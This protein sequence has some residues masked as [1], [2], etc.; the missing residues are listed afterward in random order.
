VPEKE[1]RRDGADPVPVR[2]EDA[3]LMRRAGPAQQFQPSMVGRKEAEPRHPCRHFASGKEEILAAVGES[4]QV[5]PDPEY[6]REVDRDDGEI[7]WR[8]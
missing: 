8:E 4:L 7:H 2:R 1:H 6:C 5:E 3:V